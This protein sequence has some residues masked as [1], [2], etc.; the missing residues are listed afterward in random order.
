MIHCIFSLEFWQVG[1]LINNHKESQDKPLWQAAC[2]DK[3]TLKDGS[4]QEFITYRKIIYPSTNFVSVRQRLPKYDS[5][6][7]CSKHNLNFLSQS[8]SYVRKKYDECKAYWKLCFH[9]NL[10]DKAQPGEKFF[11]PNEHGKAL[12]HKQALNKSPRIQTGEKFYKCSEC[13]KVFIQKAN[14][15]VHQRI[16]TGEKPYECCECAKTFSQK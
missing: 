1:N 7:K 5:W 6:G 2:I 8:R 11:E 16:H 13:G 3:E 4:G 12:H 14:L 9:S 10:D 15:V